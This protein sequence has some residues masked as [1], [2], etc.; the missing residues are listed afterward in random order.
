MIG[1]LSPGSY[2]VRVEPLDDVESDSFFNSAVDIDF[3]ASYA[4]RVVVAP[5]GGGV[6]GVDVQ[7][8]SR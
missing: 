2:V 5:P 1:G 7:V 3:R 6:D 4:S 8:Q